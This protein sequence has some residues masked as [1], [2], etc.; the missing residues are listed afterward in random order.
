MKVVL[1]II[2]FGLNLSFSQESLIN[3]FRIVKGVVKDDLGP[4]PGANILVKG[5]NYLVTT[6][7]DGY[8]CLIVPKKKTIYIQ[9]SAL[10]E[11]ILLIV[12]DATE[13]ININLFKKRN[14]NKIYNKFSKE[15]T[16]YFKFLNEFYNNL[17][18]FEQT[19]YCD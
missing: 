15:N 7:I 2:F 1:L 5:T 19:E 3:K 18:S 4:I 14:Y 17:K 10:C 16:E 13:K 6:N 11:P 12:D 8:F 9:I